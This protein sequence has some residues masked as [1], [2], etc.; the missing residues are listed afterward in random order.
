MTNFMVRIELHDA[1]DD[2]YAALH[3]AMERQGF[4][5]WVQGKVSRDRLPTAEYNMA[6]T[7]LE[8]AEVLVRAKKAAKSTKPRPTPWIIVTELAG[9]TWSGLEPWKD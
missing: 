6:D 2:D 1:D 8:R 3:T 7:A 5:R 9:R 4:V